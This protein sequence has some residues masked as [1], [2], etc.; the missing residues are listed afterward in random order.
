MRRTAPIREDSK[1]LFVRSTKPYTHIAKYTG[2]Q[3]LVFSLVHTG[4]RP[5]EKEIKKLNLSKA[6]VK[7]ELFGAHS[8]RGAITSYMRYRYHLR[9]DV[10]AQLGG[11]SSIKCMQKHYLKDEF[12]L[13]NE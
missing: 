8:F 13:E 9:L 6:Q 3:W 11:W 5:T 12:D 10:I 4:I 7:S 2:K 1:F